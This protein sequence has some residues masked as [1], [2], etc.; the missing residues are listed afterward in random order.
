M[1]NIVILGL[2]LAAA[3]DVELTAKKPLRVTRDGELKGALVVKVTNRGTEPVTLQHRDVHGFRFTPAS[4]EAAPW[5]IF[6]SCECGFDQGLQPPPASRTFTLAPG[7]AKTL[8][9][10]DFACGGGPFEAPAA[11]RYQV[12]YSLG[13]AGPPP[14]KT[15]LDLKRC[16]ADVRARAPGPFESKPIVVDVKK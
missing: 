16:E 1:T 14:K 3:V 10:D 13:E 12:T 6:H 11:G 5:R 7:E 9:F 15:E 2:A 8:T 4:G